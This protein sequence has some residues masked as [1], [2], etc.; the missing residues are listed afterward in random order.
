M[1]A[2]TEQLLPAKR[3]LSQIVSLMLEA[4]D[5]ADGEV[6]DAIDQLGLALESKVEAYAAVYRHLN[7]EAAAFAELASAYRQK[8]VTREAQANALRTRLQGEMQR[9]GISS[10]KAPTCTASLREHKSVHVADPEAFV[11]SADAQYLRVTVVP[12]K[13][14]IKDAIELGGA[15]EGAELVTNT[16]VVF[17]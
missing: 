7:A 11:K 1:T 10:I 12:N 13:S 6:T 4:I 17:R 2:T 9:L 8:S 15:V 16:Y 3:T 5:A 14:S